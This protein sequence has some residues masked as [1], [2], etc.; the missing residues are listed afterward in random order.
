MRTVPA[1]TITR[2]LWWLLT[3]WLATA[4]G[5]GQEAAP[6][7]PPNILFCIAD[8]WGW[9]HA[10]AYGD[11]VV[12]TPAFDRVAAEGALFEHCY[13]SSPSCTPS[14]NAILTGQY[15]WRLGAGANLWSSLDKGIPVYPLLLEQA[16]YFVGHWRKSWGPGRVKVGGYTDSHPAG[17]NYRKGFAQFLAARAEAAADR[18]FCFWLGAFDPHRG[19]KSG[20]GAKSG[21]NL[22]EVP[23]PAFWPNVEEIRSD[24]ADYYFEVQ[25]FDR[26]C[27]DALRLLE[28]AGELDNTI[29]VITGDHGMPFPRCKSNCYDMGVRVPL[30]IRWGKNIRAGLRVRDFVSLVDIAP[31]FLAAAGCATPPPMNGRSLLPILARE[32]SGG[33]ADPKRR[34]VIFGKERH[35][36]CRPDH[37]G[38]PTR[39]IRTD[40]WAYLR[41]FEPAR[42]PVGDPPLYGDT[43]PARGI[44]EGTTKGY[45]LTHKDDPAVKRSYELCFA[46]RPAEELYDMQA[47]PDQLQNLASDPKYAE[48]AARL[49]QT[50]R[51]ELE[52]TGDPRILGGAE[53]FDRFP[54]YGGSAWRPAPGKPQQTKPQQT[55]PQRKKQ[56]R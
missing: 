25:R 31:T 12:A 15:H 16:G 18:P 11:P 53:Q 36:P 32:Q 56:K 27:A 9:P 40:R 44:G 10:S 13:V 1:A 20:S 35:V 26:D 48:V 21:M 43:D 7:R 30:A 45:L 28:E 4:P 5:L 33:P 47:D 29:V 34:H 46:L 51:G 19:Y 22:D 37:S 8:D 39:G 3:A 42:W 52:A 17:K 54:Y 41:N 38:Y 14:R 49:W 50:L 2:A 55:K 24:I 6:D 23:V